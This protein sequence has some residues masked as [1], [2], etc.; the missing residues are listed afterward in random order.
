MKTLFKSSEIAHIWAHKSAPYGKSPGAMSFQGECFLS[1]GTVIARHILRN[2]KAAVILNDTSYSVSTSK[3]Q[4]CVRQSIRGETVFHIG[5]VGRGCS[6]DFNGNEGKVLFEYAVGRSAEMLSK[7]QSARQRKEQYEGSAALWLERAQEVNVFFGLRRK[8]DQQTIE[9]LKASAQA[10]AIKEAKKRADQEARA[11]KEQAYAFEAWKANRPHEYFNH[12]I[13]PTVF[14]I[15]GDELVSTHGARV[16]VTEAKTALCFV[17]KHKVG[18]WHRNGSTC[19]VG[20]YQLDSIN[21]EGV[22]AGCH[23]ITWEEI[24]R[25]SA[26]L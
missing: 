23:R 15:E 1:Y 21:P 26:I 16:P 20:H 18:G 12:S 11:R 9:R 14:R 22:K 4:G 2:G 25:L 17:L 13:F 7:S 5:D 6:L 10:S 3:H 19:P 24:E 8:V